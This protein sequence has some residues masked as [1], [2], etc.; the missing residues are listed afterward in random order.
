MQLEIIFN[1]S[2]LDRVK[3]KEI[4][5]SGVVIGLIYDNLGKQYLVAYWSNSE[6][7]TTWLI[8]EEIEPCS[9]Q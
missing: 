1:Y 4:G 5:L 7:K 6:R 8:N 3:I 2:L 9:T